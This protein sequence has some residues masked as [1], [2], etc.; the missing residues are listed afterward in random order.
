MKKM[1]LVLFSITFLVSVLFM[2]SCKK[3][4]T[5]QTEETV[6]ETA[7]YGEKAE[8]A[9]KEAGEEE[10][11]TETAGYG[12]KVKEERGKVRSMAKD[13]LERLYK[14]SPSAKAEVESAAGY[15]VFSNYGMQIIFAGAGKGKG[16]VVNNK[17]KQ[18]TFMKMVELQAGFGLGAK[19]FNVIFVFEQE[20]AL[21]DFLNKGWEFGV[22]AT[23]AAKVANKGASHAGAFSVSPGIWMYQLT[24]TGLALE[25]TQKGT[26]YYKD[27]DLN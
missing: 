17:T 26:K 4:E 11:V 3:K 25:I 13:N 14:T 23:A 16:V 2:V 19:K 10:T 7:G 15:G 5:A 18:E 6:T 1:L 24:E 12:E 27:D 21:N 20:Q 8:E 22:Q 9:V